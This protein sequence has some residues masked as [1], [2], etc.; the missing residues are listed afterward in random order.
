VVR[1]H[2]T[3]CAIEFASCKDV[4]MSFASSMIQAQS[5]SGEASDTRAGCI[6]ACVDCAQACTACADACLGEADPKTLDRCIRLTLDCADLCQAAARIVSRQTAF[7]AELAAA[8]LQACAVSSRICAAE[9]EIHTAMEHCRIC[10]DACR[11]CERACLALIAE[12]QG[13]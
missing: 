13:E 5:R 1:E 10:A 4:T 7:D 9:C 12:L 2:P 6:Q 3:T 8:A 11:E